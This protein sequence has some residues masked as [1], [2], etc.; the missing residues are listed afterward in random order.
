M[1]ESNPALTLVLAMTM[2]VIAQVVARHLRLPGIVVLLASG[3][4]LGPDGLAWIV[5]VGFLS[6]RVILFS[7]VMG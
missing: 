3:V 4:A 2:G 7:G 5:L 1:E 6:H